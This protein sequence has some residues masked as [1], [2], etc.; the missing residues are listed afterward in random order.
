MCV[1]G[2]PLGKGIPRGVSLEYRKKCF[3]IFVLGKEK[4]PVWKWGSR[5]E[6]LDYGSEV[7]SRII[8]YKKVGRI[9]LPPPSVACWGDWGTCHNR[10]HLGRIPVLKELKDSFLH[11]CHLLWQ[12]H[13]HPERD[14]CL[15]SCYLIKLVRTRTCEVLEEKNPKFKREKFFILFLSSK[16]L[17]YSRKG[18]GSRIGESLNRKGV[19][20]RLKNHRASLL[21]VCKFRWSQV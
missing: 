3:P 17:T 11:R 10:W 9:P 19:W 18:L 2:K 14:W 6:S 4:R 7:F 5:L 20:F 21:G 15:Y 12:T 16:L 1:F 8:R 13:R